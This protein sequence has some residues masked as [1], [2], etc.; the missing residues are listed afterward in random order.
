MNIFKKDANT[1]VFYSPMPFGELPATDA[2]GLN[3]SNLTGTMNYI[4]SEDASPVKSVLG[5]FDYKDGIKQ[6]AT[7]VLNAYAS[8][9]SS[10]EHRNFSMTYL[11]GQGTKKSLSNTYYLPSQI[12]QN[13][14][15]IWLNYIKDNTKNTTDMLRTKPWGWV[16]LNCVGT[17]P[18]TSW[19]I[20]AVIRHNADPVF[21]HQRRSEKVKPSGDTQGTT[22]GGSIF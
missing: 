12:A 19:C 13:L 4:Y 7:N 3:A 16:M 2:G 14:N 21:K 6:C 1:N 8:N 15:T 17:E 20:E 18:T 5:G 11:G 10:S 9:Y 22:N